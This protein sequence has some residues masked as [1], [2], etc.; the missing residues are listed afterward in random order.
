MGI[1][2]LILVVLIFGYW[3]ER[4][5]H[6]YSLSRPLI[7][8]AVSF[9]LSGDTSVPVLV[10]GD[11]TGVGVG[12]DSPEGSVAG[13]LAANLHAT[14]VENYAKSGAVVADVPAQAARAT[15]PHYR[16]ILIQIG[17]N[18]I[19]RF[20]DAKEMASQV[21]DIVRALPPADEVVVISAGDVGAA[22]LFPL[23]LRPFYTHLNQ[24]YHKE[25]AAALA[26]TPARYIDLSKAPG[27][28]LFTKE[29]EVYLAQDQFHPSDKGYGV[30]FDAIIAPH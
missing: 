16:F 24:K 2:L 17:G 4:F 1:A 26:D 12:A 27:A 3:T 10:L 28:D 18:D 5:Y 22:K 20:H 6:Y 14:N 23:P 11:S 21:A 25:Y 30:W 19:V 9:T 15:L 8:K 13:R 29:P 7:A